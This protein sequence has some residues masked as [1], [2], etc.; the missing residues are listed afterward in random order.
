VE[1]EV[2]EVNV[3]EAEEAFV[4]VL[5]EEA[6]ECVDVVG[7][8]DDAVDFSNVIELISLP[9]DEEVSSMDGFFEKDAMPTGA[10]EIVGGGVWRG[11]DSGKGSDTGLLLDSGVGGRTG[12]TWT[13]T[14][15]LPSLLS[16]ELLGDNADLGD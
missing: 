10:P 5:E 9:P 14:F 1:P 11:S 6:E 16:L 7:P 15:P 13:A 3:E 4:E 8:T 2:R 12:V